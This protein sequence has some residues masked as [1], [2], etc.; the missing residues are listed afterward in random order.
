MSTHLIGGFLGRIVAGTV[1]VEGPAGARVLQVRMG[2]FFRADVPLDRV[3]GVAVATPPRLAGVG[4][5]GWKGS[6]VVNGRLGP[7]AVVDIDP[8]VRARVCSVP[9]KAHRLAL[10]VTRPAALVAD[11]DAERAP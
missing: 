1:S 8:P 7:A 6:W 2:P 10:G 9:V 5:H 3:A 4:V 11:L